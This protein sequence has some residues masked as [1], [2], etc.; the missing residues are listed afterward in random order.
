MSITGISDSEL[1]DGSLFLTRQKAVERGA[2]FHETINQMTGE[3][4][5]IMQTPISGMTLSWMNV[6]GDQDS[7][8]EAKSQ[9]MFCPTATSLWRMDALRT[10][11]AEDAPG[12]EQALSDCLTQ[13][14]I[15]PTSD[16]S[17]KVEYDEEGKSTI[18]VGHDYPQWQT[19]EALFKD[20]AALH[21]DVMRTWN[22][23]GVLSEMEVVAD[24][25]NE[26]AASGQNAIGKAWLRHGQDSL[27]SAKQN[28]GTLY[29]QDGKLSF[30]DA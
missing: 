25:L 7:G 20:N 28:A 14:G 1:V 10:Q 27:S 3:R 2:S 6:A 17:M 5:E 26:N 11:V 12:V 4:T 23:Q 29:Y 16:F 18:R 13:A 8:G 24:V 15:D 21:S 30:A 9:F 22:Q 19:V